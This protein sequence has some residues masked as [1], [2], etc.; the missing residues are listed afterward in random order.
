MDDNAKAAAAYTRAWSSRDPA[1][2]ALKNGSRLRYLKIGDGPPLLLIHTVR[3]QLDLFQRLV[4]KLGSAYTVYAVDLPGFGWSDIVP[5]AEHSEPVMRD[6][7]LEFIE[8]L[9]LQ[10][11]TLAGESIGAVLALTLASEPAARARRVVAFNAYDYLPGLERANLLA[12]V[13][14]KSVRAPLIGPIFARMENRMI[15]AG[16]IKGG[17]YD[18]GKMP[19]DFIDELNRVGGRKG[20]ATVA[21]AV[22]RNLPSFVR[23]RSHYPMIKVPVTLVYGDHD[24]SRPAERE[25]N[26]RDIAGS[27]LVT[28]PQTGHFASMENPDACARL[29][30]DVA[31]PAS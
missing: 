10:G 11:A 31:A 17:M 20:Y 2:L 6:R 21:R 30:L 24:W 23:A 25:A 26:H 19:P 3:T 28:L 22:Y 29:L 15:L 13:I 9:G 5:G 4:P 12:S 7:M 8:A 1:F 18:P 27:S 16:I 14:I